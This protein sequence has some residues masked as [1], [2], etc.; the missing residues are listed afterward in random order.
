M[1][2]YSGEDNVLLQL[3]VVGLGLVCLF[4]VVCCLFVCWVRCEFQKTR[5]TDHQQGER[6]RRR[7]LR[8]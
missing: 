4:V 5:G 3:R 6:E 7:G 8:N 2:L 1:L